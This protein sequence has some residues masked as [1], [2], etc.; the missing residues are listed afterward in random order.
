MSE[1]SITALQR[2]LS[3]ILRG[4]TAIIGIRALVVASPIWYLNLILDVRM[5]LLNFASNVLETPILDPTQADALLEA[6]A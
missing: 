1:I 6:P 2:Y 5:K 3:H 4:E